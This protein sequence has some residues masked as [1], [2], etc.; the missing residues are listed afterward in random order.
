MNRW[1]TIR[2]R[3]NR[4]MHLDADAQPIG[5]AG[6]LEP[7]DASLDVV[8][9]EVPE[10][11]LHI[12]P[13]QKEMDQIVHASRPGAPR[14]SRCLFSRRERAAAVRSSRPRRE[15]M[16]AS[17]DRTTQGF[18]APT[19]RRMWRGRYPSTV[20]SRG[21]QHARDQSLRLGQNLVEV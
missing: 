8:A 6:M 4:S 1:V 5:E 2:E 7:L 16:R 12:V 14:E 10:A 21:F 11:Q 15:H 9:Q 19:T 13:G 18:R 20:V 3:V 17:G